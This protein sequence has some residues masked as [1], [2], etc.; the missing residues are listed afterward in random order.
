MPRFRLIYVVCRFQ[1]IPDDDCLSNS[2]KASYDAL[3]HSIIKTHPSYMMRPLSKI[4]TGQDSL[5]HPSSFI[6]NKIQIKMRKSCFWE[7]TN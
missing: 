1:N 2:R 6:N 3:N 5:P 4:E 7:C